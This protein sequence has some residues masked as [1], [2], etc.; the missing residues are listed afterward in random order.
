MNRIIEWFV[1]NPVAANLMMIVM[2]VG[3]VAALATV[4]QEEF[5]AIEIQMVNIT[6]EYRGASPA[7]IEQSICIRIEEAIEGT[8]DLD[9][10]NSIAAEGVCNVLAELRIGSD[11]DAATTEIQN[12]IDA[13]DTFPIEAEKPSVAKLDFRRGVLKIAISGEIGER[14]L[15]TIGQRAREEIAALPEVSQAVLIFDRPFEI[16]IEVSEEALRRHGLDLNTVAGAVRTASL[17]L[18]G[19]SVKTAG[20][21][22]LLRTKGQAYY[23]VEFE[24]IVVLTRN[25]GTLVR[26]RDIGRVV[27]GFEDTELRGLFNGDPSVVVKVQLI[28]NEDAL[29]AAAA[30]KAWVPGF[31][32]SVPEGVAVTVFNDESLDLVTRLN[33][34]TKNGRSG[35]VLVMVTLALFLRFRLAM[36]V[37]AGVPISLLGALILFPIFGITISTMTV[38]AFIL[39]L[40]VLV[41]DAIVIGESV[42]T[43][44]KEIG[45]Q[46]QAAIKGTQA[47]YIP[48][49]FGVMTSMAAFLPVMLV[50]GRMGDFFGV[51]GLTAIL[52]LAFSLV[53]SQLILPAHLAHRRTVPKRAEPN[54]VSAGWTA[55]QNRMSNWLERMGNV[56]YRKI[57]ED[58]I[59]WRYAVVTAAIGI[60]VLSLALISSGRLRYQFF[61]QVAGNVTYA[62]LTM[63]Q[64]IP[65]ARTELAVAQIQAAADRLR[66]EFDEEFPGPSI[67]VHTFG[68]IGEQ[69]G[70]G[71]PPRVV[72]LGGTHL[73]ELGMELVPA[74][75]REVTTDEVLVRW[76]ELTGPV[77]DAVELVFVSP[78]FSAGEPVNIELFGSDDI[79][80]LTQA[81]EMVKLFLAS[82]AGVL[83]ISD[84]FRA[85]KQEVQLSL[86][87]S[88]LPLGLTQNDLAQQ[89]REAFYGA[90][91][92]RIQ[93]GRDDVRVMVR[94]PEAERHSLGSLEEMRIR[95][96]DGTEVPFAAV[97]NAEISRGFASIRRL[98]RRRVVAVTADVNRSVTTP[99]RVIAAFDDW[100]PKLKA[101][102]PAV[103]YQ[104]GGEQREQADAADGLV[105]GFGMAMMLIYVLLAIPLRSYVQ[106]LIIMSVI[107]FGTVG[108]IL[109]HYLLGW[110]I[111]FFSILGMVALS[112]VVVNASLVLVHTINSHRDK[113]LPLGEAVR[114]ASVLRFRPIVLTTVTTF[115]GLLPLMFE[116]AVAAMPLI[117][118]AISLGFGVLYASIMTLFFVPVGYVIL[119]DVTQMMKR[120]ATESRTGAETVGSSMT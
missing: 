101:A 56:H 80:E 36:W 47:V 43:W 113:G 16:S 64:G 4:R 109:G 23:G 65:L 76:R 3:G 66:S 1:H 48:V 25:D 62:T 81:S 26:L 28:G 61:P 93:R 59:E 46:V 35:L 98:D 30:V 51:I 40:G 24:E 20:G 72:A 108:A 103:S 71:G 92:Q 29:D 83:D 32:A 11:I 27:D 12:R 84:S 38:M 13:I 19:G 15:K 110:D 120:V 100:A 52:C 78:A 14:D 75:D 111:V 58:V 116:T 50:P 104:L 114:S 9:R 106:P 95:T 119:N 53:E 60:L 54:A 97:A 39:V 88:A 37:A 18:P 42:H 91:A 112:G 8:P 94:Y 2:V 45:N 82:L 44:E 17:D 69:L 117:P 67:V 85:G 118:M 55:F 89:V 87:E 73:A 34:V 90:E 99:D 49:F 77:P 86:K 7:E 57:L 41:D 68:S 5:P 21:E 6:V 70:K 79:T 74:A 10:I 63:P 107:P 96:R 105:I 31:R 102:F 33:V 22:I 115:L